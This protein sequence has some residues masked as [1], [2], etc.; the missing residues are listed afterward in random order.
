MSRGS[1]QQT[2]DRVPFSKIVSLDSADWYNGNSLAAASVLVS[3]PMRLRVTFI[4]AALACLSVA[5]ANTT[6]QD[7]LLALARAAI[8]AEVAGSA[9]PV[10]STKSPAKPV[11]VTI[12]RKGRVLGCRGTLETRAGS[13]EQEIV[14][15]ARAAAAHDPRYTPLTTKDFQVTITIVDKLEAIGD[16]SNLQPADGLVLKSGTKVGV[17]L[18]WEGKDPKTRLQ[19]AYKKAGVQPGASCA[20]QRM[21]AERFRG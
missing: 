3:G 7:R 18:P 13:L 1:A 9:P 15:A 8:N 20:L 11:F 14:L 2:P 4:L 21:K 6:D 17:V 10:V 12:E 16:V 5:L 19:W